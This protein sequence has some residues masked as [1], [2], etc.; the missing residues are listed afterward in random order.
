MI[1]KVK[2]AEQH[3]RKYSVAQVIRVNESQT[4]AL[5]G[6][7]YVWKAKAYMLGRIFYERLHLLSAEYI[8]L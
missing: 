3:Q 2:I 8:F 5:F 4:D 1:Q 7:F 6:F